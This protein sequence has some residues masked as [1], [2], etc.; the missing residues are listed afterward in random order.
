MLFRDNVRVERFR[1]DRHAGQECP[2]ARTSGGANRFTAV[3]LNALAVGAISAAFIAPDGTATQFIG[4]LT[5]EGGASHIGGSWALS[6]SGETR[7]LQGPFLLKL[8]EPVLPAFYL[9]IGFLLHMVAR[10][11]ARRS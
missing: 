4:A 11:F 3:M 1:E 7:A 9:T 10:V 8:F 2:A 5:P 6:L